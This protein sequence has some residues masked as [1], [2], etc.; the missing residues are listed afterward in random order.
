LILP[1]NAARAPNPAAPTMVLAAAPLEISTADDGRAADHHCIEAGEGRMHGLGQHD[2]GLRRARR[3][4]RQADRDAADIERV[5][6]VDVLVGI[7]RRDHLVA[8]DLR[9]QRKLDQNPV[10]VRVLVQ[11]VDLPNH[12]RLID[13]NRK[14]ESVRTNSDFFAGLELV[15]DIEEGGRIFADEDDRQSRDQ[16]GLDL[17]RIN[18][19]AAFLT[20]LARN[21][22]AINDFCCHF[23]LAAN[24]YFSGTCCTLPDNTACDQDSINSPP[25]P[26][27]HGE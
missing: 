22:R 10:N 20:N 6:S 24:S 4:R 1:T 12:P 7:D 14:V 26:V 11:D 5:K 16:P 2:T 18:A 3:E 23:E 27:R 9:R 17:Q 21:R 25:G 19:A 8:V 15:T 13:R